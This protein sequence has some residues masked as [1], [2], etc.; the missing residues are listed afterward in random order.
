MAVISSGDT[1]QDYAFDGNR[2]MR[3][4]SEGVESDEMVWHRDKN[5]REVEVISG[6]G[7]MFQYDNQMP[8]LIKG[9]DVLLIKAMEFHRLIKGKTELILRITES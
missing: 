5:D 1:Y 7:W 9:G 6:H 8:K 3:Y 2:F 4:F